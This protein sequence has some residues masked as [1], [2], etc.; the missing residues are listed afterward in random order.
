MID[1]RVDRVAARGQSSAIDV[2]GGHEQGL[3][4]WQCH[5]GVENVGGDPVD[6]GQ[7]RLRES[8]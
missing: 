3:V 6:L 1:I 7:V 8:R 4:R 5:P 2:V